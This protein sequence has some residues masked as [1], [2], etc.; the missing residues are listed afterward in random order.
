MEGWLYRTGTRDLALDQIK[1]ERRRA[2]YEALVGMFGSTVNPET[3]IE[4]TQRRNRIR[5]TLAAL[6]PEQVGLI[7]LRSEGFSYA[8]LAAALDLKPSSVGTFWLV[9]KQPFERNM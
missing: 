7:L 1:R 3:A 8:E 9:R 2:R 5:Q 4:E 6:R